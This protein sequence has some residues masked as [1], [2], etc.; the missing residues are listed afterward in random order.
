MENN[1]KSYTVWLEVKTTHDFAGHT[2]IHGI[3]NIFDGA[4]GIY[5]RLLWLVVGLWLR[6]KLLNKNMSDFWISAF[7]V[8]DRLILF[9]VC[10]A[11]RQDKKINFDFEEVGAKNIDMGIISLGL[12]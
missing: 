3:G 1:F 5:D 9:M 8:C 4:L 11:H 6:L 12:S 2:S 7:R 10:F